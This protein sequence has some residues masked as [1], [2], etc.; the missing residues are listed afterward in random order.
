MV[1]RNVRSR[2]D[3][4][5]LKMVRMLRRLLRKAFLLTKRVRVM[6][7]L[8]KK[9]GLPTRPHNNTSSI[10]DGCR[11][12]QPHAFPVTASLTAKPDTSGDRHRDSMTNVTLVTARTTV[13]PK[14][15]VRDCEKLRLCFA[16]MEDGRLAVRGSR[17]N[18]PSGLAPRLSLSKPF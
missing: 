10:A 5:M 11:P 7:E 9:P 18:E 13:L 3:P 8:R 14:R 4:P 15:T 2:S 16:L 1:I 12:G 17:I 6:M